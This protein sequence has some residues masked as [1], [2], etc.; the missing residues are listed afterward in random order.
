MASMIA[1]GMNFEGRID[2]FPGVWPEARF[3]YR[4]AKDYWSFQYDRLGMYPPDR[5]NE[6]SDT[7]TKLIREH[8]IDIAV[9]GESGVPER[10][11]VDANTLG[12]LPGPVR[13][14]IAEHILARRAPTVGALLPK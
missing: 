14:I 2:K 11:E 10:L 13:I 12:L 3:T 7:I 8:L 6:V 4:I 1:D 9:V 5:A